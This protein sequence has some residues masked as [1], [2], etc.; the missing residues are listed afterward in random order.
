LHAISPYLHPRV[1]ELSAAQAPVAAAVGE[2][3]S[4]LGPSLASLLGFQVQR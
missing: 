3:I 1:L 4:V 2:L